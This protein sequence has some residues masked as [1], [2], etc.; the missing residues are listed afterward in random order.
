[1]LCCSHGKHQVRLG[2]NG[3]V[4]GWLTMYENLLLTNNNLYYHLVM[5][6]HMIHLSEKTLKSSDYF[7]NKSTKCYLDTKS[8]FLFCLFHYFIYFTPSQ[9]LSPALSLP[10]LS[11]SPSLLVPSPLLTSSRT[12]FTL[13]LLISAE[14]LLTFRSGN[15][16]SSSETATR[17]FSCSDQLVPQADYNRIRG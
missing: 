15:S 2:I 5:F 10:P 7:E 9:L 13:D 6:Q 1:M 17:N 3:C 8:A 11:L 4:G 16:P 14:I 12:V